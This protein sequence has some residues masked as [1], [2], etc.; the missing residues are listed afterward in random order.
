MA[1]LDVSSI[2]DLPTR[3]GDLFRDSER[4]QF[5]LITKHDRPAILAVVF[6]RRLL[7]QG[8]HVE[9]RRLT[10]AQAAKSR[11][12]L[13]GRVSRSSRVAQLG[14]GRLSCRRFRR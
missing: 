3:Q 7:D 6:D 8:V 1:S 14:S 11:G 4:G 9:K 13:P 12:P 5:A 2:C 10:L